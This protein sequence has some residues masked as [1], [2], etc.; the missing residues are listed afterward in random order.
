MLVMETHR[1]ENNIKNH[2]NCSLKKRLE[3]FLSSPLC[4]SESSFANQTNTIISESY[5]SLQIKEEYAN[6]PQRDLTLGP[7]NWRNAPS[8]TRGEEET[9]SV[10]VESD[11]SSRSSKA[12][13]SHWTP[14]TSDH[15]T[16]LWVIPQLTIPPSVKVSESPQTPQSSNDSVCAQELKE[17][18]E[19]LRMAASTF[20]NTPS[21]ISKSSSPA[22]SLKRRRQE[23]DSTFQTN[24]PSDEEHS[25]S[26]SPCAISKFVKHNTCSGLKPL[27]RRLEFN[28][29]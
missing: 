29:L 3:E 6:I 4:G 11:W 8:S 16:N 9:I 7:M 15:D 25:V 13:I 10:S 19:R 22:S 2:W 12:E 28:F 14:C 18:R 26:N 21:I 20:K 27:E 23:D 24:A 5:K 1:S 17:I